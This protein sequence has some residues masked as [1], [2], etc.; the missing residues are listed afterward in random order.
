MKP[1]NI[2]LEYDILCHGEEAKRV[3]NMNDS[4][5]PQ[6]EPSKPKDRSLNADDVNKSQKAD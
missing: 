6:N 2:P 5:K 3:L 1:T 4:T